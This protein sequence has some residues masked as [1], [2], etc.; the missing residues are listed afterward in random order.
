MNGRRGF[1]MVELL[2]VVC[3]IGL[4]AGFALP[5]LARA[6][7]RAQAAEAVGAMHAIQLGVTVFYESAG[8]WPPEGSP[9]VMPSELAGYLPHRNTFTGTGWV[10]NWRQL[11]VAQGAVT[12]QVGALELTA[13][14]PNICPAVSNLLGGPSEAVS[15]LCGPT[16]GTVTQLIER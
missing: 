15:V 4:L 12:T 11:S 13:V 3:I 9:G 7:A 1:T 5:R 2:I 8:G 16:S 6:K 14:D 10:L